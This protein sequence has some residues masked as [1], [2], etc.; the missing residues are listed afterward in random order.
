MLRHSRSAHP[1]H[2]PRMRRAAVVTVVAIGWLACARQPDTGGGRAAEGRERSS[3]DTLGPPGGPPGPGAPSAGAATRSPPVEV[4]AVDDWRPPP[5]SECGAAGS[6]PS[7]AGAPGVRVFFGCTGAEG[8]YTPAVPARR[9]AVPAGADAR[10]AAVRA[11]LAGP[12]PAERRAGFGSAFGR[13]SAGVGFA[14]RLD[15]DTAT[16]DFDRAIA[17]VPMVF[18][19][20]ATIAQIVATLG[21]FPETRFVRVRVGG[22]PLCRVLNEC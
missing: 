14:L 22:D 2:R 5:T 11:L 16:L 9:V 13:G 21:Q 10:T 12:S 19:G 15:A 4:F 8:R 3:A 6:A 18:V 20:R 7:A 17:A 1:A